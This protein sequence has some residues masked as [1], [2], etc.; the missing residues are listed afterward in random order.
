MADPATPPRAKASMM[1]LQGLAC[2]ALL[3]FAPGMAVLL[4]V[5]LAPAIAAF[6]AD[7]EPGR[8]TTRSVAVACAAGAVSPAWRL[9]P[10]GGR[11]ESVLVLLSDPL[12]IV[13]AWGS[14]ACA[15]ALCQVAPAILQSVWSV[16]ETVRAHRIEA[17]MKQIR[18]EWHLE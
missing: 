10:A 14:G 12:T 5:L 15:W 16:R 13:L 17:E 7:M 1:W 9:W 4:A 2:G 6:A 11:M 18:E 8:G 3:A